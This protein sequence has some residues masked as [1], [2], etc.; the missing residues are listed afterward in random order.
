MFAWVFAMSGEPSAQSQQR[1]PVVHIST[2]QPA[3]VLFERHHELIELPPPIEVGRRQ[4]RLELPRAIDQHLKIV[5]P[6]EDLLHAA[7]L[8][9]IGTGLDVVGVGRQFERVP[10]LLHRD[11]HGVQALGQIHGAGVGDRGSKRRPT[12]RDA[13]VDGPPPRVSYRHVAVGGTLERPRDLFQPGRDAAQLA[14][15]DFCEQTLAGTDA[16]FADVRSDARKGA[17]WVAAD[18]LELVEHAQ[19][20]VELADA[21]EAISDLAQPTAEL[22]GDSVVEL[23]HGQYF[24]EAAGGYPRTVQRLDVAVFHPLQHPCKSL[25]AAAKQVVTFCPDGGTGHDSRMTWSGD[26]SRAGVPI[27]LVS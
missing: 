22:V 6:P 9:E 15:R 12:A 5:Q 1:V 16:I 24:A 11:A 18:F 8:L 7:Q 4:R 17:F 2:V 3:A 25:E 20:H 26:Y 13:R 27:T 19:Q 14:Y 21:P 10:Q 23:Q